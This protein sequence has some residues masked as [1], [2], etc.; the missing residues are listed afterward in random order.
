[1]AKKIT[2]S[3]PAIEREAL[4]VAEFCMSHGICRASYYNLQR[5]GAGPR[6]M[7]IGRRTLISVAA[8]REWRE[9]MEQKA[10]A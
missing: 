8:A 6:Q 7:K 4:S 2:A 10:A 5:S 3:K 1:M 9:L